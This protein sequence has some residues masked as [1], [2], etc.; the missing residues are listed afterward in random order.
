MNSSYTI[1]P[2][3][4]YV[5]RWIDSSPLRARWWVNNCPD[6]DNPELAFYLEGTTAKVKRV[7]C[8]QCGWE[9]TA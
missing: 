9:V 7:S 4:K 6:C 5:Q 2:R 3:F 8:Y 1:P